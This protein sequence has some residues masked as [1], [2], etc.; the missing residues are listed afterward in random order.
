[1]RLNSYTQPNGITCGPTALLNIASTLDPSLS[2]TPQGILELAQE[3]GVTPQAGTGH[4]QMQKGLERLNLPI[5]R[6]LS[7]VPGLTDEAPDCIQTVFTDQTIIPTWPDPRKKQ[8]DRQTLNRVA[9]YARRAAQHYFILMRT[10]WHGCPHW[11]AVTVDDNGSFLI[12]D[13]A[14][15]LYAIKDFDLMQSWMWR[16]FDCFLIARDQ[17]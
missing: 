11:I 13:G 6:G 4:V 17:K 3:M 10:F 12:A 8:E 14:R 16:D 5:L 7:S 1:M 9:D 15:A 2:T